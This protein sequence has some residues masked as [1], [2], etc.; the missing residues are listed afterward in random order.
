[1]GTLDQHQREREEFCPISLDGTLT[2]EL[3]VRTAYFTRFLSRM[4]LCYMLFL[5]NLRRAF[6]SAQTYAVRAH[7]PPAPLHPPPHK[8]ARTHERTHTPTHPP[9]PPHPPTPT[10]THETFG[11]FNIQVRVH[12]ADSSDFH[13]IS[14]V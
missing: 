5:A 3:R 7:P 12:R 8:Q 4:F 10:H 14:R 9:T 11:C 2:E 1:M 13:V 6:T